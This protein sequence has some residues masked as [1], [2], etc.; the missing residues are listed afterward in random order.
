ME[1][2]KISPQMILL[3]CVL[4]AIL[5]LSIML[6]DA[7]FIGQG[8]IGFDSTEILGLL[9]LLISGLITGSICVYRGGIRLNT[10]LSAIIYFV[11]Y[12]VVLTLTSEIRIPFGLIIKGLT[13]LISG[14]FLGNVFGSK[15]RNITQRNRVWKPNYRP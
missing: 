2:H 4:L 3:G 14:T 15:L 7:V 12:Y 13:A 8:M 11:L 9:S 1:F 10:Y 6:V 5:D